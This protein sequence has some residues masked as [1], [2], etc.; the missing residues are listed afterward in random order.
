MLQ[1]L[2]K[3]SAWL[4]LTYFPGLL[5]RQNEGYRYIQ[6]SYIMVFQNQRRIGN[7][8]QE[9]HFHRCQ[10]L[11]TCTASLRNLYREFF[12]YQSFTDPPSPSAVNFT[13]FYFKCIP[14][15]LW[16]Y[17]VSLLKL[18]FKQCC[19][20]LWEVD[21]TEVLFDASIC[22]ASHLLEFLLDTATAI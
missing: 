11:F 8:G 21:C 4:S 13:D 9:I 14:N 7:T 15:A 10:F 19:F 22:T 17:F 18:T 1:K 12:P 6:E 20:E 16:Y 3:R 5:Q 2:L